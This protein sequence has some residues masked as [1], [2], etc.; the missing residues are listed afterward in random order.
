MRRRVRY[1][2]REGHHDPDTMRG[3]RRRNLRWIVEA[4]R[5]T[6]GAEQVPQHG[7]NRRLRIG[8]NYYIVHGFM[9]GEKKVCIVFAMCPE[10]KLGDIGTGWMQHLSVIVKDNVGTDSF[11]GSSVATP[12]TQKKIHTLWKHSVL[13]QFNFDFLGSIFRRVLQG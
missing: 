1:G 4:G 8:M 2:G 3:N 6:E 7:E 12:K 9:G 5:Y 10:G 11:A 13:L